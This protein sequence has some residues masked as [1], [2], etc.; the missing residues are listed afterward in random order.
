MKKPQFDPVNYT[1]RAFYLHTISGIG[2]FYCPLVSLL[3]LVRQIITFYHHKVGEPP[4]VA[5][6][7][8]CN[9]MQ[10]TRILIPVSA[11]VKALLSL[12][13]PHHSIFG[14]LSSIPVGL[15]AVLFSH[16]RHESCIIRVSTRVKIFQNFQNNVHKK[17][18]ILYFLGSTHQRFVD[19]SANTTKL[20]KSL[21]QQQTMLI[22]TK[23]LLMDWR[24][25]IMSLS[26]H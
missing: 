26:E 21:L 12:I 3:I 24:I 5:K 20:C 6:V 22:T 15:S 23:C 13:H 1:L 25:R 4:Q 18:L 11:D 2:F 19:P 7:L 14:C 16:H 17:I 9:S 10:F 8:I